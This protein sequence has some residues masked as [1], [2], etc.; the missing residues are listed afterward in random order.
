MFF[1]RK[2][3]IALILPGTYKFPYK[4][5]R[6]LR[7]EFEEVSIVHRPYT[8]LAISLSTASFPDQGRDIGTSIAP[9]RL[10][11]ERTKTETGRGGGWI[12]SHQSKSAAT[13]SK[14][15]SG[16]AH[17]TYTMVAQPNFFRDF[18]KK[19]PIYEATLRSE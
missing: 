18:S 8:Y 2:L 17:F 9:R 13:I 10:Q 5:G 16:F 11:R 15:R 12:W 6:V 3:A 7:V 14:F 19:S 4:N 1:P